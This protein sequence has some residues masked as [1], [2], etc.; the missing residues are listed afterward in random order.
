MQTQRRCFTSGP[1]QRAE[2]S[3][4]EAVHQ[5]LSDWT[6]VRYMLLPHCTTKAE[7]REYLDGLTAE[8]PAAVWTSVVR[9]IEIRDSPGSAV[10]LCRPR[11]GFP[12]CPF[13]GATMNP[14]MKFKSRFGILPVLTRP[15]DCYLYLRY[16]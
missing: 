8:N 11:I 1:A 6:V 9:A 15:L 3:D 16:G 2:T 7:S 10:G 14:K 5:F 13:E 12:Q 4:L